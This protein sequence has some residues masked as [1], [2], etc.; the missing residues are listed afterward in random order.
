MQLRVL[1]KGLILVAVPVLLEIV[2]ITVL[3]IFLNISDKQFALET[4]H[5]YVAQNGARLAFANCNAGA[6]LVEAWRTRDMRNMRRFDYECARVERLADSI[7]KAS[8]FE[9]AS[10]QKVTRDI[11]EAQKRVTSRLRE[12]GDATS[13]G[14]SLGSMRS[15]MESQKALR[16]E[17]NHIML[18]LRK[19]YVD[20]DRGIPGEWQSMQ[21]MQNNTIAVLEAGIALNVLAAISLLLYFRKSFVTPLNRIK[22]NIDLMAQNKPLL[23]ALPH[24]DEIGEL[25]RT[26]HGM[27][28]ELDSANEREQALF[29][30]NSDVICVINQHFF[31]QRANPATIRM[32]GIRPEDIVGKSLSWVVAA[33]QY[34]KVEER[35]RD[36]REN[37][38]AAG[39]TCTLNLPGLDQ[40][41]N[42]TVETFWSIF[43]SPDGSVCH[44]VIHDVSEAQELERQKESYLRLIAS[45]FR[46]PLSSMNGLVEELVSG[47]R[48]TLPE[49]ASG[50]IA[51]ASD[52][53]GRL[54]S[55]V[56]ELLDLETLKESEI[57]LNRR[58]CRV[59]DLIDAV[60]KD[61]ESISQFKKVELKVDCPPDLT[62][63]ADFD[64]MVRVLVNFVSNAVKFSATGSSVT[65]KAVQKQTEFGDQVRIEVIDRGRGI[66]AEALGKLFQPFVQVEHSDSKRGKGTG[67][68]LVVCKRV[69]EQHG[70]VVGAESTV[71][72]GSSFWFEIPVKES[73]SRKLPE[74]IASSS[75][76]MPA[77]PLATSEKTML[78]LIGSHQPKAWGKLNLKSKGFILVGLPLFC[79]FIFVGVML[80]WILESGQALEKEIHYRDV[81]RSASHIA[82][83]FLDIMVSL[84]RP[85]FDINECKNALEALPQRV[86]RFQNAVGDDRVAQRFAKPVLDYVNNSVYAVT[87]RLSKVVTEDDEDVRARRERYANGMV[88]MTSELGR[89]VERLIDACDAVNK[90]NP[91]KLLQLRHTQELT[92]ASGL[93]LNIAIAIWLAIYFSKDIVRRLLV[94]SDNSRRL[95]LSQPLNA[96]LSGSDEIADL[97][98]AFHETADKLI[99]ARA[100]ES[101][102][103]DNSQNIIAAFDQ[104]GTFTTIN[105][106]CPVLLGVEGDQ[107]V[108]RRFT[109]F[110]PSS[111]RDLTM[112]FL[113]EASTSHLPVVFET[114]MVTDNKAVDLS[115]SILW[116]EAEQLFFGVAYDI[117]QQKDLERMKQEFVALV[118]HDLRTPLTTIQGMSILLTKGAF[119]ELPE[120]ANKPL[121]EIKTESD[122]I[123]ELVND[124]LDMSR[125]ESG[126]AKFELQEQSFSSVW[127]LTQ[128]FNSQ[129]GVKISFAAPEA[130]LL[131]T[132]SIAGADQAQLLNTNIVADPEKLPFA[133]SAMLAECFANSAVVASLTSANGSGLKLELRGPAPAESAETIARI[134]AVIATPDLRAT[135]RRFRLSIAKRILQSHKVELSAELLDSEQSS[136]NPKMLRL[137]FTFP[138]AKK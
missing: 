95:A 77:V 22:S 19:R 127:N 62:F 7:L 53:L 122:H 136:G 58:T 118:T 35:I 16:P 125:L 101:A 26:L 88:I 94:M 126:E 20:L 47:R 3:G 51:A 27:V 54:V 61:T 116:S 89:T 109:D 33:D 137:A 57:K 10:E 115:W 43:W 41:Q 65:I 21:M 31:F 71:G 91:A 45:D 46:Q 106:A 29:T 110:L 84:R 82:M 38:K 40:N 90:A 23:P 128:Q 36:A 8:P 85:Q 111:D 70:G 103:L 105:R 75:S 15:I 64:R 92:L 42:R 107:I 81:A 133:I 5:V 130:G 4:E 129:S 44:C 66:P 132:N 1:Q 34:V 123:L 87:R 69:V 120:S 37:K 131:S 119:G 63:S 74:K 18:L 134:T 55:M 68:G 73:D 11:M 83:S 113:Q 28:K 72:E 50:K 80:T 102:F 2:L 98:R 124:L 60:V 112:K 48:G 14:F 79:Q 100:R 99:E 24:H 59:G 30:N 12:I 49:A 67:L 96:V 25:D 138:R 39:F 135:S 97:D 56:D 117:T 17:L 13:G 104:S 121:L 78:D 76:T 6:Y 52:T 32:W 9:V 108:N 114:H 86:N 93:L